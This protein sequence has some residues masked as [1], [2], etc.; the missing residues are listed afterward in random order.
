[1]PILKRV[2]EVHPTLAEM[3]ERMNV[4]KGTMPVSSI[5]HRFSKKKKI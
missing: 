2:S 4:M 1:M 3:V 5:F